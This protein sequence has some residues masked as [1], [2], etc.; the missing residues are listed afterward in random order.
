MRIGWCCFIGDGY[1][2]LV[3]VS[4]PQ[5]TGPAESEL[6]ASIYC[7]HLFRPSRYR[8]RNRSIPN[9][10]RSARPKCACTLPVYVHRL[11]VKPSPVGLFFRRFFSRCVLVGILRLYLPPASH[12]VLPPVIL[13]TSY[14]CPG[15]SYG[16]ID[17]PKICQ[18]PPLESTP[19]PV[20]P[21]PRSGVCTAFASLVGAAIHFFRI[22]VS[23]G[24]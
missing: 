23:V 8:A 9:C 20:R 11:L 13:H 12:P 4:R 15:H 21:G 5:R 24:R 2:G 1:D 7:F 10:A 18:P 19:A 17:T 16:F 3:F 22:L 14:P 6:I